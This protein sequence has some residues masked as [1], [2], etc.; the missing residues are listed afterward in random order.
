[1]CPISLKPIPEG[2]LKSEGKERILRHEQ[3]THLCVGHEDTVHEDKVVHCWVWRTEEQRAE[4]SQTVEE[5]R[6]D[7]WKVAVSSSPASV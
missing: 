6:T 1:M 3:R 7:G 4:R 2:K 5:G